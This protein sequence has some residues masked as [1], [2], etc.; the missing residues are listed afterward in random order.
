MS[1]K[2]S[3]GR[4]YDWGSGP[5]GGLGEKQGPISGPQEASGYQITPAPSGGA[6]AGGCGVGPFG[7]YK[8]SPTILPTVTGVS[9]GESQGG[10]GGGAIETPMDTTTAM[11]MGSGGGS[12]STGAMGGGSISSPFVSPWGDSVGKK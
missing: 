4:D 8:E 11:L 3:G 10:A 6:E 12:D 7:G 2:M 5:G 1:H 9:V